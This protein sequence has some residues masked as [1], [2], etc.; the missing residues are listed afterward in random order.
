MF[1]LDFALELSM[2]GRLLLASILGAV[3]G[4]KR[5]F[6]KNAAGFAL[7]PLCRWELALLA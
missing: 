4:M 3:V 5:E 7:M 6:H 2:A 1:E